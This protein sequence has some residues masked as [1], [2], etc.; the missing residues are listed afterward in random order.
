M[1]IVDYDRSAEDPVDIAFEDFD[2]FFA[3]LRRARPD[4]DRVRRREDGS[5]PKLAADDAL[6]AETQTR[7]GV[8]LPAGLVTLWRD[9]NGRSVPTLHRRRRGHAVPVPLEYFVSLAD[10]SDRIVFSQGEMPWKERY[11]GAD[12]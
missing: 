4:R 8:T 9:K 7:L 2:A 6:I 12:R 5:E 11:S 10:L 3:A 1:L